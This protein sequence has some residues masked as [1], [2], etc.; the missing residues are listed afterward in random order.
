MKQ[1]KLLDIWLHYWGTSLHK[2]WVVW[3]LSKVM[4]AL[5]WRGLTH[6]ISKYRL[7][8]AKGFFEVISRLRDI[9]YGSAEYKDC[10]GEVKGSISLHY[11]R[12]KHHPEHWPCG[13]ADM[14]LVDIVEM[15]CDWAAAV[16]RHKMA[17][18]HKSIM[19][20][21]NRFNLSIDL[22][23]ILLNQAGDEYEAKTVLLKRNKQSK[24][25]PNVPPGE[26]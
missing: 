26:A 8:E 5:F 14:N 10:L 19:I 16:H 3:Y 1:R 21:K 22:M 25:R 2:L 17:N 13:H 4:V 9:E 6:D 20:N 12:S 7:D 18:L 23:E 24:I 11:E 15:Y